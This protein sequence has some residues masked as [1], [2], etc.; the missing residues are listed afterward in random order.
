LNFSKALHSSVSKCGIP[1]FY[2]QYFPDPNDLPIVYADREKRVFFWERNGDVTLDVV[3]NW[4]SSCRECVFHYHRAPDPG[5]KPS[6]VVPLND[7]WTISEWFSSSDEY[8]KV[9]RSCAIFVAPRKFEGI[10]MSFLEAMAMGLVVVGLPYP[11]LS[12][13]VDNGINGILINID[14]RV[15]LSNIDLRSIGASAR[16]KIEDGY[17]QY[18]AKIPKLERWIEQIILGKVRLSR[19]LIIINQLR[20]MPKNALGRIK[21]IIYIIIKTLRMK[22]RGLR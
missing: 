2:L 17:L 4:F 13:Y 16:K 15:D 12:E 19:N 22:V 10:G 1:S 20:Q 7:T 8:K 6:S 3:K 14:D 9:L 21:S 5:N 11:T 18:L